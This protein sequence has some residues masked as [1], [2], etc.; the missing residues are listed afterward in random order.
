M[1]RLDPKDCRATTNVNIPLLGKPFPNPS[2]NRSF[3]ELFDP[4]RCRLR[5]ERLINAWD[6]LAIGHPL[7]GPGGARGRFFY[8]VTTLAGAVGPGGAR[9]PDGQRWSAGLPESVFWMRSGQGAKIGRAERRY[10]APLR[11]R[12]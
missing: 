4:G 9:G 11:A 6:P 10:P 2:E 5:H 3:T 1:F 8:G 12:G 7:V